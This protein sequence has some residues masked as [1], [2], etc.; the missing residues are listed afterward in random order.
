MLGLGLNIYKDNRSRGRSLLLDKYPGAAAAYSLR[1]LSTE[2]AG[3]AVVRVRRE[4]D[5]SEVDFTAAEITDGTLINWV[6][7]NLSVTGNIGTQSLDGISIGAN[8][9][10]QGSLVGTVSE[11]ILYDTNQSVDRLN[12]E[13]NINHHY[14]IYDANA[15]V[16]K[17]YDQ[18]GNGRDVTQST[19]SLQP[20][21]VKNGDLCV[22]NE[23]PAVNFDGNNYLIGPLVEATNDTTFFASARFNSIASYQS[24]LGIGNAPL[25]LMCD[26]SGAKNFKLFSGGNLKSSLVATTDHILF[27]TATTD[28]SRLIR[29]NQVETSDSNVPSIG[30]NSL[31]LGDRT[32]GGNRLVADVNEVVFYRNI[33]LSPSEIEGVETNINNYYSIY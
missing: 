30:T 29:E 3:Q 13:K 28:N 2:W 15:Y 20:Y 14:G 5:D 26:P 24:I 17:W 23:L 11:V 4:S 16:V 19:T 7:G 22:I 18:S 8:Y 33:K 9:A 1:E 12:I 25:F 32:S 21:I 27:T 31:I 10:K 6:N